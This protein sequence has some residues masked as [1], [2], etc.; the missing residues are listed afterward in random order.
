[1][2]VLLTGSLL[3]TLAGCDGGGTGDNK[4]SAA[5]SP[6]GPPPRTERQLTAAALSDGERAGAYTVSTYPLGGPLDT[7]YTAEPAACQ[8][9]VSLAPAVSGFRPAAEVGR[10]AENP[11]ETLGVTVD[12]QLRSYAG[13]G[14]ARVM[15]A[16]TTAGRTCAGGFTEDRLSLVRAK[17]LAV[18]A[19]AAPRLGDSSAAY[20]FTILDVRGK[21]KL[22]EYLT[23]VRSGS[24][25]LSFRAEVTGT[26]DVGAVP[27]DVIRAQWAKFDAS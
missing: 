20:R 7:D 17:Y 26:Q 11:A 25:T 13:Q 3:A 27:A 14:A 24:T 22:Y 10:Q 21:K 8:P 16:L 18:E 19:V 15:K 1:M 5:P 12:I 2:A 9:L 6:A 4:P 23:V